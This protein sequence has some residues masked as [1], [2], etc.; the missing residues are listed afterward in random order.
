MSKKKVYI[1]LPITG[2]P[3]VEAKRLAKAA[4]KILTEKGY[5][6][7]TPFD[8]CQETDAP[9]SYY[10][11][12]DIM[13]LLE[14]DCVYFLH[15]WEKSKGCLLEYAAAKIYEKKMMFEKKDSVCGEHKK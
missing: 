5:S 8:V 15:G 10:M 13:S 2:R 11:G 1:S 9:Y 4:K 14:C 7:I 6:V 12:K 3:I